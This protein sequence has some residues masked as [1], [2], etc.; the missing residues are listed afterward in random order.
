[1]VSSRLRELARQEGATPFMVLLAGFQALLGRYA[2]QA[3]VAVGSPVAGRG[4]AE[5]EGLVGLF[6]NTLVLRLDL[7]GQPSFRQV[8]G[9]VPGGVCPSGLAVRASGGGAAAAA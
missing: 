5:L 4:R 6:V 9:G 2:G 1:A 7:D 3:D 8:G